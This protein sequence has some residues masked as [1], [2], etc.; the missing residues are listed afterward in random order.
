MCEMLAIPS[1]C[2]IPV[3]RVL[4]YAVQLDEYGVADFSWDIV[5]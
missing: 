4:D 3:E 2:P 1:H 5:R